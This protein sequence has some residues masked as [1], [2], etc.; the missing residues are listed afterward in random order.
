MTYSIN[1]LGFRKALSRCLI[2]AS[3]DRTRPHLHGI[4]FTPVDGRIMLESTDGHRLTRLHVEAPESNKGL[5]GFIISIDQAKEMLALIPKNT[6]RGL[7]ISVDGVAFGIGGNSYVV[8]PLDYTFPDTDRV[9][10][11]KGTFNS[12]MTFNARYLKEMCETILKDSD[13]G[14]CTTITI[15]AR[16][17]VDTGPALIMNGNSEDKRVLMPMRVAGDYEEYLAG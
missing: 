5:K 4:N 9:I 1:A 7:Y 10:P 17:G 14:D 12:M 3:K 2:T 15:L 16:A 6:S 11:G 13:K 8:R